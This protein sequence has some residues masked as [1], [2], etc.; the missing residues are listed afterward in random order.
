MECLTPTAL[1]YNHS[2][3]LASQSFLYGTYLKQGRGVESVLQQVKKAAAHYTVG[4][5]LRINRTQSIEP[6]KAFKLIKM[7]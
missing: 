3:A 5:R 4:I 7:T 1:S 6:I 2:A